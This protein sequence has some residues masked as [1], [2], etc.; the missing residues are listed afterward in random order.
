MSRR[1][2]AAVCSL[3]LATACASDVV[4]LDPVP[5]VSAEPTSITVVASPD[6]DAAASSDGEDADPD[7]SPP[8]TPAPPDDETASP[9]PEPSEDPEAGP[10][11]AAIAAF[12]ERETDVGGKRAQHVVTDL[13]GDEIVEVVVARVD[14][15]EV[16]VSVWWW[17][18]ADGFGSPA[19][20]EAGRGRAV[21][22]VR[23]I[24][25]TRDDVRE[26][27]VRIGGGAR[28]SLAAWSV[29]EREL[30]PL[31]ATGGCFD[32]THVYG[33]TGVT[34]QARA[35]GPPAIVATCDDSPLP[36]ADWSSAVYELRD[37]AYRFV[38]DEPTPEPSPS[39]S[40]T[41]SPSPSP[42]RSASP[43]PTPS[44]S[45]SD[46]EDDDEDEDEDE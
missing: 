46:D 29:A 28:D 2:V 17:T 26:L 13:D 9:S 31:T 41:P 24:D 36:V 21:T 42:S 35:E 23:A 39:P 6:E 5:V 3:A 44:P 14:G 37:G 25:L 20:G 4:G 8:A 45:D 1:L 16:T 11:P 43:S 7:E 19:V 38:E 15:D 18:P 30:T 27:L 34:L 40:P 32:G 22:E 10:A 12:V 33:A